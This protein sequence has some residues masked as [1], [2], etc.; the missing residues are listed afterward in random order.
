[1]PDGKTYSETFNGPSS[2]EISECSAKITFMPV[3]SCP[4]T[5]SETKL[6]YEHIFKQEIPLKGWLKHVYGIALTRYAELA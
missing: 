2:R 5:N 1:M 3:A 6:L 4:K